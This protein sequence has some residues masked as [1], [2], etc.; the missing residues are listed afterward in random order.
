MYLII[1][2]IIY[3]N[4]IYINIFVTVKKCFPTP[5]T[6]TP[7]NSTSPQKPNNSNNKTTTQINTTNTQP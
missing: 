1:N 2:I 6:P 7:K 4:N 5:T 3:N